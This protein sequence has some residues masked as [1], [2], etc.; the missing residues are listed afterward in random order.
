[1]II[2][3]FGVTAVSVFF[4]VLLNVKY[5]YI[6]IKKEELDRKMKFL[7]A[8]LIKVLSDNSVM[9]DI[10]STSEIVEK[11]LKDRD[12]P[13]EIRKK[14]YSGDPVNVLPYTGSD[15]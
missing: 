12:H 11:Y 3:M 1:M 5:V 4:L 8:R 7:T 6:K 13:E 15:M 10:I 14:L 2:F 9:S